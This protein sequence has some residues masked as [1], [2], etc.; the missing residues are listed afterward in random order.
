[1]GHTEHREATDVFRKDRD[2]LDVIRVTKEF[3]QEEQRAAGS[4]A[5]EL[6]GEDEEME[7]GVPA[8]SASDEE[9]PV[10]EDESSDHDSEWIDSDGDGELG[11]GAEDG[12]NEAGDGYE[13]DIVDI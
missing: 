3:E 12:E 5:Q 9:E 6:H 8:G 4:A 2:M 10:S 11:W 7:G 1:M 13:F